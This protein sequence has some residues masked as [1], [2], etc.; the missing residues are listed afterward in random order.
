MGQ[1]VEKAS[2]LGSANRTCQVVSVLKGECW[3][4]ATSVPEQDPTHTTV[5]ACHGAIG[6]MEGIREKTKRRE[7]G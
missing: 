2:S 3:V 7:L 6:E 1:I 4:R 5:S